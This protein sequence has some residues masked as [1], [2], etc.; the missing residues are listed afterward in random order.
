[1]KERRVDNHATGVNNGYDSWMDELWSAWCYIGVLDF[2]V[3]RT[4]TMI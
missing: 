1:M 4:G 3:S 2:Y